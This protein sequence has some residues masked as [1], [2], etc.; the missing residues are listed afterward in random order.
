LSDAGQLHFGCKSDL[1]SCLEP[2]QPSI[3]SEPQVDA[4]VLDGAVIVS[5]LKPVNVK[6]FEE[7]V[8]SVFMPYIY[9]QMSKVHRLD[10]VWDCY[11][12]ASVKGLMRVKRGCAARQQ[13]HSSAPVPR[14][15]QEF[16]RN[17]ENKTAL[18]CYLADQMCI[19]P[20]PN[21][22]VLV[23]TCGEMVK[24]TQCSF[25]ASNLQPCTH[26]EA[27]TRMLLHAADIVR[28]GFDKVVVRTVD[29]DV[30]VLAIAF[31]DKIKCTELWIAFGTGRHFRHISIHDL[32]SALGPQRSCGLPVF[33]SL[34]G[35]DTV[36]AFVGRGRKTCWDTWNKYS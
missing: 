22:K 28:A 4:A 35:C 12:Q 16:L 14:N 17:D 10:V 1:L 25:D 20:I 26:E 21:G 30:V 27:D 3:D 31:H 13:V 5:M 29:T 11:Q 2:L 23:S 6:T 33:H 15:W 34:S 32:A 24:S 8:G 18:F 9:S 36:S 7:Y 19:K